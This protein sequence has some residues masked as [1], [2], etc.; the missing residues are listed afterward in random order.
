MT[1]EASDIPLWSLVRARGRQRGSFVASAGVAE[2]MIGVDRGSMG[3]VPGVGVLD[4]EDG[5]KGAWRAHPALPQP[6][7][8]FCGMSLPRQLTRPPRSHAIVA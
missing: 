8:S 5:E 3:C 1:P 2:Q 7:P 4:G 6:T